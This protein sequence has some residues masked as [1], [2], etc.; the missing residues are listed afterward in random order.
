VLD[1]WNTCNQNQVLFDQESLVAHKLRVR[2][3][4]A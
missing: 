3:P 2:R 1:I 4:A